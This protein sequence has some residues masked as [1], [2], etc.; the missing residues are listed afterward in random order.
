MYDL[1]NGLYEVSFLP[2]KPGV[3]AARVWL[4]YTLCDGLRDPPAG[5]FINGKLVLEFS[6][7]TNL[8]L[9]K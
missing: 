3:Y 9:I 2:L 5:W 4:D 8:T 1:N 7:Q 6:N